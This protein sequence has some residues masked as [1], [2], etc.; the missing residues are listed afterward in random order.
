[1]MSDDQ[2]ANNISDHAE[3]KMVGKAL[4]I[5]PPDISVA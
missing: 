3:K 2:D 5:R 1:M 4:Q